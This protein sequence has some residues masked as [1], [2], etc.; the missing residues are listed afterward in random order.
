MIKFTDYTKVLRHYLKCYYT[1]ASFFL[2]EKKKTH[3]LMFELLL[4]E[5]ST[6]Q[7]QQIT[8]FSLKMAFL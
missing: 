2:M 1:Q 5:G 4:N 8:G 7:Q 6:I 3:K